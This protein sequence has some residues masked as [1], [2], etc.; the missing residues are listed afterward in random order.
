MSPVAR[1]AAW[2]LLAVL[3]VA[4]GAGLFWGWILPKA[5]FDIV[6]SRDGIDGVACAS[7]GSS[8]V[9]RSG[10]RLIRLDPLTGR[11]LWS[12]PGDG[13]P[14]GSL[15]A[16]N[17]LVTASIGELRAYRLADGA[18]VWKAAVATRPYRVW[19]AA[20]SIV[21]ATDAEILSLSETDGAPRWKIPM[22][23]ASGI[24]V[25]G[26]VLGIRTESRALVGVDLPSGRERW[27]RV[28][29]TFASNPHDGVLSVTSDGKSRLLDARTGREIGNLRIEEEVDL[30]GA[31]SDR[32]YF[33]TARDGDLLCVAREDGR[34]LWR[35]R[36]PRYR[37]RGAFEFMPRVPPGWLEEHGD[38]ILCQGGVQVRPSAMRDQAWRLDA[39]S[40]AGELQWG[41]TPPA[42]LEWIRPPFALGVSERRSS[43]SLIRIPKLSE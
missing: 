5:G 23:N 6:W 24:W 7:D 37:G 16:W 36:P 20:D 33:M 4:A 40:R 29:A 30:L 38:R 9:V 34:P 32:L 39:Y 35:I 25:S 31:S 3:L 27:R 10:N 19:T 22:E 2:K 26:G 18:E 1:K 15:P 12:V 13:V 8:L 17:L 11:E 41:L 42:P 28:D 14:R 21:A 43:V